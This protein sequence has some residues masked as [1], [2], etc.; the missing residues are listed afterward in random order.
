M[1]PNLS[2]YFRYPIVAGVFVVFVSDDAKV[3]MLKC[4]PFPAHA[5]SK[6]L[7]PADGVLLR[8]KTMVL[9]WVFGG[10]DDAASEPS[11]ESGDEDVLEIRSCAHI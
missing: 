4:A 5:A 9:S 11:V 6:Y 2:Y 10:G 1:L 8:D 7:A 3:N